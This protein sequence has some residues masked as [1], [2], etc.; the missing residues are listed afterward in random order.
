MELV[1]NFSGGKDSTAMLAYVCETYPHLPKQVVMADTGWEHPDAV[2]WSTQIVGRFGL[3]LK[4][5]RNPHKDFLAMVRKRGKFPSPAQRQCTSDLK[6]GPIQTWIRRNVQDKLVINCLGL[7]AEESP[8]RAK[9][10]PLSRDK[11]MT[12]G[13]RTVWNWLPIHSWS[14]AQVLG[15]LAEREL[16]LHPV[17]NHL[18]RFSCR[19]CIYMTTSD[20]RA[21]AKHDPAAFEQIAQL[22]EEMGFTMQPGRSVKEAIQVTQP[23]VV[24]PRLFV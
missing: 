15:Y 16:P 24:Q 17:Y 4:V 3:T 21:V 8:G 1:I 10:L 19:V 12:N 2:E 13:K 9:K 11:T 22:E 20:L 14:E 6:R 23:A 5:V 7:R 18:R